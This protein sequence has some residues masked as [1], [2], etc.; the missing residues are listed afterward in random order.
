MDVAAGYALG[1]WAKRRYRFLKGHRPVMYTNL[2]TTGA[3]DTHLQETERQAVEMAEHLTSE[4]AKRESI[5]EDM[6]AVNSIAWVQAMSNI[7]ARVRE[8]VN[9]DIIFT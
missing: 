7:Q 3:L 1:V 2:L 5:N 6:K 8:V 4:M 9:N